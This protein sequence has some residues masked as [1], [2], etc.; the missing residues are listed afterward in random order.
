MD[1]DVEAVA[2]WLGSLFIA[3]PPRS[4]PS[5][6]A[7]PLTSGSDR[8]ARVRSKLRIDPHLKPANGQSYFDDSHLNSKPCISSPVVCPV[9]PTGSIAQL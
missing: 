5:D 1:R 2:A 7:L 8:Q 9:I 6:V 4:P 3:T